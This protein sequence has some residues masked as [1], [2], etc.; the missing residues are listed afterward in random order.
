M[1][2]GSA[3][4]SVNPLILLLPMEARCYVFALAVARVFLWGPAGFPHPERSA[5]ERV[6][7]VEKL[8]EALVDGIRRGDATA[9]LE[10]VSPNVTV[11]G[12][13]DDGEWWRGDAVAPAIRAQLEASGGFDVTVASPQAFG[14]GSFCVFEDLPTMSALQGR[15]SAPPPGQRTYGRASAQLRWRSVSGYLLQVGSPGRAPSRWS[16]GAVT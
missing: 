13:T 3:N 6:P 8:V 4:L 16:G 14:D 2:E 9:V 5:M 15:C 7:E 12:G 10:M 11:V 1:F